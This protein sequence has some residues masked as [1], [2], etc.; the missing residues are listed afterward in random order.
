MT[1][2]C[3]VSIAS[4]RDIELSDTIDSVVNNSTINLTI[5]VVQQCHRNEYVDVSKWADDRVKFTGEWMRPGAAKGAGYARK[6]ALS[7]YTDEDYF[8]QIDSHTLLVQNWDSKMI[9]ALNLACETEKSS[10]VIL[11]QYP[12]GYERDGDT[13]TLLH[14]HPRYIDKPHRQTPMLNKQGQIVAKRGEFIDVPT[15]STTL[16]AGYIF[17]PGAFTHLGYDENISFWGEEFMLA[18]TAWLQGWRIYSPHEMYVWHHYGRRGLVRVWKDITHW[19]LIEY[20]SHEYQARI[21]KNLVK[22]DRYSLLHED[23]RNVIEAFLQSRGELAKQSY[24]ET[25]IMIDT[26][27]ETEVINGRPQPTSNNTK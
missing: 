13:V 5:S 16:L 25:D 24:K 11:S 7:Y 6:I 23:H 14:N 9:A 21:F 19:P 20:E 3:F 17:G 1:K 2:S 4:Y 10:K 26:M 8:L 27:I 15:L 12:A 18:I 22:D